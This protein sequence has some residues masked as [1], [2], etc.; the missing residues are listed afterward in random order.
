LFDRPW[1]VASDPRDSQKLLVTEY[2]GGS[3]RVID[4]KTRYT[5]TLISGLTNPVSLAFD[6]QNQKMLISLYT[7]LVEY[8]FQAEVLVNV[9][10]G[11][12]S[13][14]ADGTL[15]E[16][17]YDILFELVFLTNEIICVADRFNNRLRVINRKTNSVTSI[18]T[19]AT[20]GNSALT[21]TLNSPM[22]LLVHNGYMYI[23]EQGAIR[24]LPG[25]LHPNLVISFI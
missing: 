20:N 7:K 9:T 12:S 21:C 8:D 16:A 19:D 15:D 2:G 24:R 3:V 17:L 13:G 6:I 11:G 18:G 23:G 22:G 4:L 10:G 5:E 25:K 14:F 1:S